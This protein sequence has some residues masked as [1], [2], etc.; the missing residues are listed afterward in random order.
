[1]TR[2]LALDEFL[3]V[4]ND[5]ENRD[6]RLKNWPCFAIYVWTVIIAGALLTLFGVRSLLTENNTSHTSFTLVATRSAASVTV[7]SH[8]LGNNKHLSKADIS[9]SEDIGNPAECV[10]EGQDL[11]VNWARDNQSPPQGTL[12]I[13]K[14]ATSNNAVSCIQKEITANDTVTVRSC[15]SLQ[16]E[17]LYGGPIRGTQYWPSQNNTISESPYVTGLGSFGGIIEPYWLTSSG[18]MYF[19]PPNVPLFVSQNES[20]LCFSSKIKDPYLA[21]GSGKVTLKYFVCSGR[22]VKSMHMYGIQS[23]LQIPLDIPDERMFQHPVWSTWARYKRFIFTN[24]ILSFADEILQHGFNN[25]Q[26]EIDDKW[27]SYY[28]SAQFNNATFSDPESMVAILKEK[29][30]RVTLWTHPFIDMFSPAHKL[31]REKGFLALSRS[32]TSDYTIWWDGIAGMINFTNKDAAAWWKGR[33]QNLS[34]NYNID[35]FKYDAGEAAYLPGAPEVGILDA[36]IRMQPNVFTTDY[37]KT[38]ASISRLKLAEVRV[39]YRNQKEAI[40]VRMSDKDSTWDIRNGL[41]ALVTS[42]LA[43]NMVGYSFVLPDMIGGNGYGNYP[44]KELFIRWLQANTFMPSIQFSY[45]PW[46]Y[47]QETVDICKKFTSLH[48]QYS[49]KIIQLAKNKVKDG[50]PINPPIWWIDPTD[51]DALTIDSEFLLGEDVLVAPILDEG[52]L[53]RDIYLPTGQWHDELHN[54]TLSGKQW[55]RNYTVKLDQLAYFTKIYVL[56][57]ILT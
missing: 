6:R 36:P 50:T 13:K 5:E 31:A 30:F 51:E 11:C 8:Q 54:T 3:L 7:W 46:D 48:Y 27:E 41:K 57:L 38:V 39:V 34:K 35:A 22:D 55:L 2:K 53:S 56:A 49:D 23:F 26:L 20:Q 1:M 33:L 21:D 4:K 37:V 45:V 15:I 29:G 32:R 40:F 24:I 19:V 43:M 17:Q 12:R 14:I 44:S 25:S 52:A 10:E 42:L 16:G 18:K 28:G 47:D 9:F